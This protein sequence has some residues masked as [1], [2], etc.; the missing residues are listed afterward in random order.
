MSKITSRPLV[1]KPRIIATVIAGA[2]IAAPSSLAIAAGGGGGGGGAT[3]PSQSAPRYDA[4]EEYRLGVSALNAEDFRQAERH[5][6]RVTRAARRNANAHYLLGV[7]YLRQDDFRKARKPLENAVKYAPDMIP[8]QRDLAIAY[9]NLDRRDDAQEIL[10]GLAQRQ[11]SCAQGCAE[12]ANLDQAVT[13]I[14]NAMSGLALGELGPDIALLAAASSADAVYS[15]AVG[16]IN[17]GQFEQALVQLD[18]AALAFGPHPDILTYQGFANRKL[19][20]YGV[21]QSYYQRALT[22]APEHIG[23]IEYYGELKVERGDLD[24]AREHLALLDQLCDFGCY[25]A[26]EL[27]SWIRDAST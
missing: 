17:E 8:A 24:G 26:E 4:A 12:Q 6:K 7:T 13:A 11:T 15:D 19:A 23:A 18:Q 25:E 10:D 5:F 2:L 3:A 22:I 9:L 1:G 21:A 27:R 14:E 20:R 16:L